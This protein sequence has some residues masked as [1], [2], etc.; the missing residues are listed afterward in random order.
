MTLT[1]YDATKKDF[2]QGVEEAHEKVIRKMSCGTQ[3]MSVRLRNTT[4][5]RTSEKKI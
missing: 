1:S 4:A 2:C 3:S 5:V